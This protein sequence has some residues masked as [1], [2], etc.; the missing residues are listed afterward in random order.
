MG[1]SKI[2]TS[3]SCHP[4]WQP[5]EGWKMGDIVIKEVEKSKGVN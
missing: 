1:D 3:F 4:S 5:R 2:F